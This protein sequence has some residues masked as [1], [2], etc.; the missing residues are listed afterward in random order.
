MKIFRPLTLGLLFIL[1]SSGGCSSKSSDKKQATGKKGPSQFPVETMKLTSQKIEYSMTAVGSVEAFETV[2]VTA[3][4]PGVVEKVLFRE[5]DLVEKDQVLVEIE[6][7]RYQLTVEAAKAN[8]EKAEATK[9]EAQ[10]ALARRES[11]V[12]KSPGLIPGEE[13]ES[14]RTKVSTANAD[15]LQLRSVLSQAD[16]NLRDAYA[17]APVAGRIQTRTVQTGQYVQTGAVL[18]TLVRRDPLLLRFQV[19]E[20]DAGRLANGAKLRFRVAGEEKDFTAKI[21]SIAESADPASRMVTITATVDEGSRDQVR[22]GAFADVTIPVASPSGALV[23]PQ[24]SIRPSERGFLAFVADGETARERLVELGLRTPD[25]RVEI[26]KGLSAGEVLV[27]RGAEALR[28]GAPIK[29][30][31]STEGAGGSGK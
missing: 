29:L 8:V 10:A 7:E 4:V 31:E 27:V 24:T 3:R 22:P 16:L 30:A 12:A 15:L 26:R 28:D 5:G 14:F 11:V 19:P 2:Q 17:R 23:V 25:G 13:I 6:P 21:V 18:A 9:R 1:A 20:R